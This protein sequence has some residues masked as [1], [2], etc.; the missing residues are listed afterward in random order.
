MVHSASI[1]ARRSEVEA[2]LLSRH[3][4]FVGVG[5]LAAIAAALLPGWFWNKM[6]PWLFWGSFSLLVLVLM[7]G[8][9]TKINGAQ[10]WFRHGSLSIQPSELMK[11]TLPLYLCYQAGRRRDVLHAWLRGTIPVAF[12]VL[13]V[14]P[15]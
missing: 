8:V 11:I 7:P 2:V 1:T 14:V 13:L 10:R 6:A 9:G 3:L 4:G 15:T 12:P 5:L